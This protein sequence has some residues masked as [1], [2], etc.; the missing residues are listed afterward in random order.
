MSRTKSEGG[1][2]KG[3]RGA[4]IELSWLLS[5]RAVNGEKKG[6][7]EKKN[8]GHKMNLRGTR[9]FSLLFLARLLLFIVSCCLIP[10]WKCL[11]QLLN[12]YYNNGNKATTVENNGKKMKNAWDRPR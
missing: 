5:K 3:R 2:G 7:K 4:R 1:R 6:K 10:L 12:S 8:A 9:L 11:Q